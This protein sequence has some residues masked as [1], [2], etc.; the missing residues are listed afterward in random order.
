VSCGFGSS[1]AIPSRVAED[2]AGV[3][4]ERLAWRAEVGIPAALA[5]HPG[6]GAGQCIRLG[7][8]SLKLDERPDFRLARG[9]VAGSQAAD[10]A[11]SETRRMSLT[12]D[13][14]KMI[15]VTLQI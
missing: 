9:R 2:P 12:C 6:E 4:D 1:R 13:I 11:G 14:P 3:N 5:Q 15:F 7:L 10:A 8:L